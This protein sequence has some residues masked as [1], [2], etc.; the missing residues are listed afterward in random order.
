MLRT[1]LSRGGACAPRRAI[2]SFLTVAYSFSSVCAVLTGL[3]AQAATSPQR[4]SKAQKKQAIEAATREQGV[5]YEHLPSRY[6]ARDRCLLRLELPDPNL[7]WQLRREIFQLGLFDVSG[8]S[9]YVEGLGAQTAQ[10]QSIVERRKDLASFFRSFDQGLTLA[11]IFPARAESKKEAPSG[12]AA[13]DVDPWLC[14]SA[15]GKSRSAL[16]GIPALVRRLITDRS[17]EPQDEDR[18]LEIEELPVLDSPVAVRWMHRERWRSHAG[19]LGEGYSVDSSLFD[20]YKSRRAAFVFQSQFRRDKSRIIAPQIAAEVVGLVRLGKPAVYE[21]VPD[22]ERMIARAILV[23]AVLEEP[24]AQAFRRAPWMRSLC[25]I[26]CFES[27]DGRML[28]RQAA[29]GR[30]LVERIDVRPITGKKSIFDALAGSARAGL[31]ERAAWLPKDTILALEIGLDGRE[32]GDQ[33]QSFFDGFEFFVRFTPERVDS[34]LAELRAHLGLAPS[35]RDRPGLEGLH[36][37]GLALVP[38]SVASALPEPLVFLRGDYAAN[39]AHE[40]LLCIAK[41][42]SSSK[43]DATSLESKIK[44]LGEAEAADRI[45]YLRLVDFGGRNFLQS[46]LG[47]GFVS[48]AKI[49][50]SLVIGGSP[51]TLRQVARSSLSKKARSPQKGEARKAAPSLAEQH[52]FQREFAAAGNPADEQDVLL[53]GFVD[54]PALLRALA[55]YDDVLPLLGGIFDMPRGA[56]DKHAPKLSDFKQLVGRERFE[57][58]RRPGSLRFEHDGGTVLSPIAWTCVGFSAQLARVMALLQH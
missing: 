55:R 8:V 43:V 23:P 58:L 38:G 6:L 32:L 15:V 19:R 16:R 10:L 31:R 11:M 21:A 22:K 37:V 39:S 29:A 51:R 56:G 52:V 41:T 42:M 7:L 57:I 36:G 4:A 49:G 46:M 14:L 48:V 50:D 30:K 28:L 3:Q 9:E 45:E 27:I 13:K 2:F 1:S 24:L 53:A 40:L 35:K 12:E 20:A 17:S 33:I 47:G 34:M 5:V 18:Q 26:D 54:G 44:S 25:G